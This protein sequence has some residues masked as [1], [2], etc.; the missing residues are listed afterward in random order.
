MNWDLTSMRS[1]MRV[2][3]MPPPCT[4]TQPFQSQRNDFVD[5]R[6]SLFQKRAADFN[7]DEVTH[8]ISPVRPV[9]RA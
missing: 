8:R 4:M 1:S 9:V 3:C 5:G 6:F 2:I 7:D